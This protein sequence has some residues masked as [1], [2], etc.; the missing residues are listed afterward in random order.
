MKVRGRNMES[1]GRSTA[2][3]LRTLFL[4]LSEDLQVDVRVYC[5]I[6]ARKPKTLTADVYELQKEMRSAMSCKRAEASINLW[7][8]Y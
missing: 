6:N 8:I 1:R 4:N 2:V 7:G 3:S 5:L